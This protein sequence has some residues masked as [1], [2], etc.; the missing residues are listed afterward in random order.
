M[1]KE[2]EVQCQAEK[3]RRGLQYIVKAVEIDVQEQFSRFIKMEEERNLKLTDLRQQSQS[4]EKQL[5]KM[6]KFLDVSILSSRYS[7]K[8]CLA[9]FD[10]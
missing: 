10:G 5:E 6:R 3:V 1:K 2:L 4:L 7:L 9:W 8:P